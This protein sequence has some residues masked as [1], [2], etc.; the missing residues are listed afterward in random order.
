MIMAFSSRQPYHSR[1]TERERCVYAA[2]VSATSSGEVRVTA[3]QIGARLL[4]PMTPSNA[5]KTLERVRF[6]LPLLAWR[7]SWVIRRDERVHPELWWVERRGESRGSSSRA[8]I[9]P[10]AEQEEDA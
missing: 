10:I 1:L 5:L 8:P 6:K 7:S 9:P 4:E 2:L 3:A